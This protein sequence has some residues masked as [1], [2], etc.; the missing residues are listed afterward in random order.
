MDWRRTPTSS[1]LWTIFDGHH[2]FR[3]PYTNE[4]H[5]IQAKVK[6]APS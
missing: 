2:M 6:R 4:I 3:D 1:L 5:I